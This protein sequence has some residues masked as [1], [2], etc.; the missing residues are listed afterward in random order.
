[1]VSA[2]TLNGTI[3]IAGKALIHDTLLSG[4]LSYIDGKFAIA[5]SEIGTFNVTVL[6]DLLELLFSKGLVPAV[7]VILEQGLPLPTVQGDLQQKDNVLSFSFRT[8]VQ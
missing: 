7:N 2:F 4:N 1:M 3:E 6:N 8:L 5:K